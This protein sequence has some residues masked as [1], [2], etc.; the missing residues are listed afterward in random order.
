MV[1]DRTLAAALLGHPV[2]TLVGLSGGGNNRLYRVA[3]GETCSVLKRYDAGDGSGRERF[4]RET[5]AA[6][7]LADTALADRVP[8]LIAADEASSAALFECIAGAPVGP[9]E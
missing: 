4:I 7:F 1:D 3:A 2:D 8:R 9:R 6:R 5:A